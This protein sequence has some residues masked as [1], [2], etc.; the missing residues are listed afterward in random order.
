MFSFAKKIVDR[1]ESG[2]TGVASAEEDSYYKNCLQINNKGYGLRVLKVEPQSLAFEKGLESWFDYIVRINNHELPFLYPALSTYN[3]SI[4]EDGT[5]NYGGEATQEQV[6]MIDYDLLGKELAK[7][8]NKDLVLD[9]WSS[10]GGTLRQVIIPLNAS[11]KP[12]EFKRE[13]DEFGR[14]FEFDR[15]GF[16][17]LSQHLSTSTHVWRIL[18]T[19]Q[20]SPAFQAQLVPY[21]D[22][23]IGCDSAFPDDP[24]SKGLLYKGGESLLSRVVLAYYNHHFAISGN[25]FIPITLFVYNHDYDVLRPVTL[26]LSRSWGTGNNRGVL[27]CDVG[28]GLL[29]RIPEVIGKFNEQQITDDVIFESNQPFSYHSSDTNVL[30]ER[31][32]AN[33]EADKSSKPPTAPTKSFVPIASMPQPRTSPRKKKQTRAHGN[34]EDLNA[35]MNEEL[36]R[37]KNEDN[38]T[39]SEKYESVVPPPPK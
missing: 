22:Y 14:L 19:H 5:L 38:N 3:Y 2:Y 27:G 26:N 16:V 10:K 25:E 17:V 33:E 28:Y 8:T 9:V 11:E 18:N 7:L 30:G 32:I 20:G 29:H 23:I 39:S 24:E 6:G 37:S 21:S 13:G 34:L 15:L 1:I 12:S 35:Y 31:E 36:E 4:N